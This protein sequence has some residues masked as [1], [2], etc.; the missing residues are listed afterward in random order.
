M[1]K[2]RAVPPVFP[3]VTLNGYCTGAALQ[4]VN[5][6]VRMVH[7]AADVAA[8]RSAAIYA[9][10]GIAGLPNWLPNVAQC[11]PS[12][13]M[14][15]GHNTASTEV[16][17]WPLR[18]VSNAGWALTVHLYGVHFTPASGRLGRAVIYSCGHSPNI[19]DGPSVRPDN[20]GD[21]DWRTIDTLLIAGYDV[22]A[23]YMP[24]YYTVPPSIT[25]YYYPEPNWTNPDYSGVAPAHDWLAQNVLPQRAAGSF[26][27]CLLTMPVLAL[28]YAQALG[29]TNNAAAGLSGGGWST[30]LIAA[31]DTRVQKSFAV[32]GS[33]PVYMR[34]ANNALGDSEQVWPDF[35][36]GCGYLD[37]YLMGAHNRHAEQIYNSGDDSVFGTAQY[38]QVEAGRV[39]CNGL[40]YS[41]AIA[42]WAGEI[43]TASAAIGTGTFAAVIDSTANHHCVPWSVIDHIVTGLAA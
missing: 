1:R 7:T 26:L 9:I 38:A 33:Q 41:A 21:G 39:R 32:A 27:R 40:S 5:D 24:A 34:P 16:I 4:I 6:S 3:G 8:K 2:F 22:F 11:S 36:R 35:Y 19:N 18:T 43:S 29:L 10:F 20:S 31:L 17:S 14:T 13:V 23:Y 30:T 12:S 28:N 25:N 37:L 42:D 15:A